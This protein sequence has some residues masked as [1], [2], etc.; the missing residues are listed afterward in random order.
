VLH[1]ICPGECCKYGAWTANTRLRV[2]AEPSD[3]APVAY[4]LPPSAEFTALEGEV[5]VEQLGVLVVRKRHAITDD[6]GERRVFQPGD[7]VLIEMTL[8][9]GFVQAWYRGSEM[10]IDGLSWPLDSEEPAP[11]SRG[12]AELRQPLLAHWWVHVSH[13]GREGWLEMT[14]S[15]D[16]DGRFSCS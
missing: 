14:E 1:D 2:R 15:V 13:E 12:V 9:E 5:H 4:Y 16:V 7:T 6:G 8:G 10:V 3:S 11:A